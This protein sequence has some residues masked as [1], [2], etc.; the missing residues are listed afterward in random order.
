MLTWSDVI[1]PFLSFREKNLP[2]PFRWTA[3]FRPAGKRDRMGRDASDGFNPDNMKG[4]MRCRLMNGKHH[5]Y[6]KLSTT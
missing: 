1:G 3:R 2:Q 5:A 4:D 6:K